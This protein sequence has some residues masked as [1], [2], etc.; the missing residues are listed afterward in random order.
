VKKTNREKKLKIEW[1]ENSIVHND[2]EI[3]FFCHSPQNIH[4]NRKNGYSLLR[5]RKGDRKKERLGQ[6]EK[7][8]EKHRHI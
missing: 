3:F 1:S 8:K 4:N 5:R 2:W 7:Q 6:K